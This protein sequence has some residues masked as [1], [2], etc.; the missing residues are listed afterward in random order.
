MSTRRAAQRLAG[1]GFYVS[2]GERRSSDE[3]RGT[4]AE[5]EPGAG[6]HRQ[7]RLDGLHLP[8]VG[9]LSLPTRVRLPFDRL[10]NRR[11]PRSELCPHG[12]RDDA[13]VG[14]ALGLWL[15]GTHDPAHG[16]HA[17]LAHAELVDRG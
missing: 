8:V 11:R 13:A 14:P 4:V 6:R 10:R 9:R 15:Q 7:P 5:T 1:A 16:P 17:V 3:R 12:R 2:M